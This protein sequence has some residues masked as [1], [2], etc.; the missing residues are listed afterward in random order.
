ML[1][2]PAQ[3][4][5]K[6]GAE[7][8]SRY[9]LHPLQLSRA[10]IAVGLRESAAKSV[11]QQPKMLV[12]PAGITPLNLAGYHRATAT[13]TGSGNI[14]GIHTQQ[15]VQYSIMLSIDER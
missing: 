11:W 14:N 3:V 7:Q 1:P 6:S 8:S 5:H 13:W 2:D 9:A 4:P 10:M 12:R 15:S